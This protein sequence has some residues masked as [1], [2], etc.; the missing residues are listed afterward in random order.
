MDHIDKR[1][2]YENTPLFYAIM[3]NDVIMTSDLLL[4]GR[5]SPGGT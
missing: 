1:D 2:E 5:A 4:K 3:S